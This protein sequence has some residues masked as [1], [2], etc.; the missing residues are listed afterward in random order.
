MKKIAHYIIL[1]LLF[2]AAV[3]VSAAYLYTLENFRWSGVIEGPLKNSGLYQVHLKDAV[4][5][6]CSMACRDLR[7]IDTNNREIP[8]VI[9]ENRNDARRPETYSLE[10]IGFDEQL[11]ETRV[12]MKMP[13]KYQPVTEL[14]F[15]IQ[16]IDFR[17]AVV[18]EGS[19]DSRS[20]TLLAQSQIY[21]FTSQVDLRKKH[22]SFNASDFRYYRLTLKDDK[23]QSAGDEKIRLKYQ[24]LDFS[25]TGMQARKLHISRVMGRTFSETE[26]TAVYDEQHP[27]TFRS[28]Q[29][30][31]RNTVISFE[32]GLPFT[33]ISFD[34]TNPYFHRPASLYSSET[35]RENSYKLLQRTSLYRFLLSDMIETRNFIVSNVSGHRFYRLII[36]NGSNPP[37]DIKGIKLGWVQK[38]LYFVALGDV[39][40]YT[41]GFGNAAIDPPG[42]D[43]ANSVNQANW[44]QF[45]PESAELRNIRQNPDYKPGLQK[46]KKAKREKM[47]LIAIVSTLVIGIGFWLYALLKKVGDKTIP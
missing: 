9:I 6:Q 3:P 13:E 47:I 7:I 38:L 39:P 11:S 45:R 31:D 22:I 33:R 5:E 44:Q 8:Y 12:T 4:L 36:E 2:F 14:A 26:T 24:G 35:G 43:L 30:R 19:A 40:S 32:S 17:K 20:W 10:V 41:A 21:D 25:V 42:Y 46:D 34:L 15:E 16:E 29:D 1:A 18:L 37:L 27:T 28:E 23:K